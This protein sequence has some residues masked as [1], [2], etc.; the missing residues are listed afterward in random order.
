MLNPV[1]LHILLCKRAQ[2]YYSTN[3]LLLFYHVD[4]KLETTFL[5]L[6]SLVVWWSELLTTNDEVPAS[7]PGS[8][9]GIFLV[10]EDPRGDHGLGS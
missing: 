8:T 10:G 2:K 1:L 5:R 9:M 4:S 6:P 7:I 3:R